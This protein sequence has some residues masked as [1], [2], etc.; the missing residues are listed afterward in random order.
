[1]CSVFEIEIEAI[2]KAS[3]QNEDFR[4]FIVFA[5]NGALNF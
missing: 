2:Y 3:T 1:M 4:Y 5:L